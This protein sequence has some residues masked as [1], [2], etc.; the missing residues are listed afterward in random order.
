MVGGYF[1]RKVTPDI[2]GLAKV[3]RDRGRRAELQV[4]FQETAEIVALLKE[5]DQAAAGSEFLASEYG[6]QLYLTNAV[7]TDNYLDYLRGRRGVV[8]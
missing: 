2:E 8:V 5:K 3:K 7:Y 1:K 4:S 6:D